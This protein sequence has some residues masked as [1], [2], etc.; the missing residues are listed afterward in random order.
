MDFYPAYTVA[1]GR[2]LIEALRREARRVQHLHGD[3]GMFALYNMDEL[4][5]P[6]E[7]DI[8]RDL[9]VKLTVLDAFKLADLWES[10]LPDLVQSEF[11]RYGYADLL[12]VG[13]EFEPER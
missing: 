5:R 3:R 2:I 4:A 11:V 1:E 6:C 13:C 7:R 10:H 9:S 12:P 8:T